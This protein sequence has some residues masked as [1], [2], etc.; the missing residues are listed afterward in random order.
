MPPTNLEKLTALKKAYLTVFNSESGK[1]VLADLELRSYFHTT[2]FND[3]PQRLA[4]NEGKRAMF[5]N[6]KSMML[7]D[8]ELIKKLQEA[9]SEK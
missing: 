5:L 7:L 6:I 4:F 8:I 9:E 2:T 1:K 3:N